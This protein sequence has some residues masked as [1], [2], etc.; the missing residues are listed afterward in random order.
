[1]SLKKD[2]RGYY[3]INDDNY[4]SHNDYLNN[5]YYPNIYRLYRDYNDI[6]QDIQNSIDELIKREELH[7]NLMKE[8]LDKFKTKNNFL[9]EW[10]DYIF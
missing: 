4:N 6:E 8:L 2:R 10:I 1:M 7:R 9:Q 3:G 5:V